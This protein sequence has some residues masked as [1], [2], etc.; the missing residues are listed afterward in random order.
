MGRCSSAKPWRFCILDTNFRNSNLSRVSALPSQHARG[1]HGLRWVGSLLSA[2]TNGVIA[3]RPPDF[4]MSDQ[5][6]TASRSA[7]TGKIAIPRLNSSKA[8]PRTRRDPLTNRVLRACTNCRVRR[9]RCD[10]RQPRC[11]KC[12][13]SDQPCVYMESRRHRLQTYAE[14]SCSGETER[15]TD[16]E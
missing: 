14:L 6:P 5:L 9:T 11:E 1:D 15:I 2:C 12:V 3:M 16:C 10:G 8:P 13:I 7:P 4:N